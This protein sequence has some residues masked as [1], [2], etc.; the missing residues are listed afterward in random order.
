MEVMLAMMLLS[1]ATLG[2]VRLAGSAM[3]VARSAQAATSLGVHAE[4]TLEAARDRGWAANPPGTTI[5]TLNVRGARYAR[6]LTVTDQSIRT[7]EIRVEIARVGDAKF[8][9]ST[10][11]YIV[12]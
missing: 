10:L 8:A 7:R 9:Y 11:T 4:N 5:D 3:L 6:R 1:A 2:L 12:R